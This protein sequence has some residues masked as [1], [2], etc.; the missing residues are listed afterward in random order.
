MQSSQFPR[1]YPA[2]LTTLAHCRGKFP[3]HHG[4][5]HQRQYHALGDQEIRELARGV[6]SRLCTQ[7]K[8]IRGLDH[9]ELGVGE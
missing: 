3:S 1:S 7:E 2:N 9:E 8:P 4:L 6:E 5:S